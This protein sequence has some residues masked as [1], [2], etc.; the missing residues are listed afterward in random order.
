MEAMQEIGLL[1]PLVS[2]P[3]RYMGGEVNS[4]RPSGGGEVLFALAFPDAY[5]IGMSYPGLQILYHVLNS[6]EGVDCE[7]V[8]CPWV[9]MEELLRRRSPPSSVSSREGPSGSSTSSASP[10]STSS[11]IPIS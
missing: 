3:S 2:R 5:E 9:D 6:L 7:R 8:F 10:S 11:P 4:R 1:L